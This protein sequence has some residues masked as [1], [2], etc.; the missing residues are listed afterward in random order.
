MENITRLKIEVE[1]PYNLT[2]IE[3]IKAREA[4]I[5]AALEKAEYLIEGRRE[6]LLQ[7]MTMMV[8]ERFDLKPSETKMITEYVLNL[9]GA[10][11]N[12]VSGLN[13]IRE[14]RKKNNS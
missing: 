1:I 4:A 9:S 12:I 8:M 5:N 6:S 2:V 3:R 7:Q 10:Y 13:D 11:S 14:E